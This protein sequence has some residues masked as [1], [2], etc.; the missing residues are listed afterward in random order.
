MFVMKYADSNGIIQGE[1]SDDLNFLA[2]RGKKGIEKNK[3]RRC[4]EGTSDT[5][6]RCQTKL[7]RGKKREVFYFSKK[8]KDLKKHRGN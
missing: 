3:V 5:N 6:K 4:S 7:I 2:G 1:K 8:N